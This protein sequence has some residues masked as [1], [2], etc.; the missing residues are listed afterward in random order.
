MRRGT[1]LNASVGTSARRGGSSS[2]A[3]RRMCGPLPASKA[4]R[5][6][7]T[8][9][10]PFDDAVYAEAARLFHARREAAG[11]AVSSAGCAA[12]LLFRA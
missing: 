6:A 3:T 8:L 1:E 11:I 9:R 12:T 2:G 4:A 10:D 5:L 7:A